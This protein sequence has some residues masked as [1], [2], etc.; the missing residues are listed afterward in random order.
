MGS[1]AAGVLHD[2]NPIFV[3]ALLQDGV[4]EFATPAHLFRLPVRWRLNRRQLHGVAMTDAKITNTAR[5]K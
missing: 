5:R 1:E 4:V 3:H 2:Q